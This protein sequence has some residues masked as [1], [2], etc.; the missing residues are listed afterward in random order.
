MNISIGMIH[1]PILTQVSYNNDQWPTP[2]LKII[3]NATLFYNFEVIGY[4]FIYQYITVDGYVS[5]ISYVGA[6]IRL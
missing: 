6:E 4:N 2:V 3:P 5:S 1:E